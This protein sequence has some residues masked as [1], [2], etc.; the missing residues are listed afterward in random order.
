MADDEFEAVLRE[1]AAA[2]Q[3]DAPSVAESDAS[4]VAEKPGTSDGS[5]DTAAATSTVEPAAVDAAAPSDS[6]VAPAACDGETHSPAAALNGGNEDNDNVD[7]DKDESEDEDGS[8]AG[9]SSRGAADSGWDTREEVEGRRGQRNATFKHKVIKEVK[10]SLRS[11]Y[12]AGRIT[13][14][15]CTLASNLCQT[16]CS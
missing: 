1:T 5:D 15:A 11:F 6:A 9:P 2:L 8:G 3:S 14:K 16:F 10:N 13:S 4:S 7:S 12:T